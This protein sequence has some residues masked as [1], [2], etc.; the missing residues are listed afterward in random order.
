MFYDLRFIKDI[1]QHKLDLQSGYFIS[2]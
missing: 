2:F 1:T